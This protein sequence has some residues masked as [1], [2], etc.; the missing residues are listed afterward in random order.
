TEISDNTR[1]V[2]IEAAWFQPGVIRRSARRFGMHT[3]A[4]HRFE[5]G[6]DVECAAW[7]ADRI[8]ALLGRLSPGVALAGRIDAYPAGFAPVRLT[9]RRERLRQAVG[10]E[11]PTAQVESILAAL[12]FTVAPS[13]QGWE[14]TV[15]SW[16][17][18]VEREID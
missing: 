6:A 7:A 3:E 17:L 12:G 9:L 13:P 11:I 16:R 10:A 5:R 4:S 15:P 1:N 18:D 2:L 8:A 14:V